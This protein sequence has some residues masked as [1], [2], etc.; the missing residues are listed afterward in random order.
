MGKFSLLNP[1][2]KIQFGLIALIVLTFAP[3]LIARPVTKC[4]DST[5][6]A[7]L[8]S[9]QEQYLDLQAREITDLVHSLRVRASDQPDRVKLLEAAHSAW[10]TFRDAECKEKTFESASGTAALVHMN[11]CLI[12]INRNRIT[13]LKESLATP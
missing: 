6:E 3:P 5:T 13:E 4:A 10:L 11:A 8:S 12:L 9:C 1:I 2:A 7:A